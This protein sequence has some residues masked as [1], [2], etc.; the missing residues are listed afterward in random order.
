MAL[1][2]EYSNVLQS[3][4]TRYI[5]IFTREKIVRKEYQLSIIKWINNLRFAPFFLFDCQTSPYMANGRCVALHLDTPDATIFLCDFYYT[6]L[7]TSA[8]VLAS[9]YKN[10]RMGEIHKTLDDSRGVNQ[11]IIIL[12]ML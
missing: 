6:S 11:N 4:T 1:L 2:S 7:M 10:S 12:M 5:F 3:A 9:Q 8:R